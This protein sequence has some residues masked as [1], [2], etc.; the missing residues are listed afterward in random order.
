MLAARLLDAVPSLVGLKVAGG[1][2]D[3]YDSMRDVLARCAVFVPGHHL[4]TGTAQGARGS[5]S[6]IAALSPS[7][8]AQW[9]ETS[10]TDPAAAVDLER[11]IAAWFA[12]HVTP[13][14]DAGV[15]NPA[16]D[17]FL[18]AAG[19][20]CDVG[21]RVRWPYDSAP[22]TAVDEARQHARDRLPDLFGG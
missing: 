14:Q 5:Y 21:L 19:G 1:G 12:R 17:K 9:Y 16:L 20:W 10:H 11:R 2:P 4:A 15:G 13:L 3:W 8:A 22:E 6:N 7:G 18:A